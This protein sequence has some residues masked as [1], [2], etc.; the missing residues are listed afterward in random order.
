MPLVMAVDYSPAI[1]LARWHVLYMHVLHVLPS[2]IRKNAIVKKD[3][4][5][6]NIEHVGA[7]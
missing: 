5:S 4:Y 6:L 7:A 2:V 1:Q 3:L